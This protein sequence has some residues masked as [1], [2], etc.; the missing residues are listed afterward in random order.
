M[1]A[2]PRRAMATTRAGSWRRSWAATG[3]PPARTARTAFLAGRSDPN[4]HLFEVM[5]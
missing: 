2:S 1:V 4:G 3:N 5:A